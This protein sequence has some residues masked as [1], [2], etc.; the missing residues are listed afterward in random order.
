MQN[1]T[2]SYTEGTLRLLNSIIWFLWCYV[3]EDNE[4][5]ILILKSAY[6]FFFVTQSFT[7]KN[8]E[9]HGADLMKAFDSTIRAQYSSYCD[10]T[11]SGT[12]SNA[13]CIPILFRCSLNLEF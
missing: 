1:A 12:V 6:I 13:D 11:L 7:F 2:L 10:P 9:F 3:I 8:I 5:P 4:R